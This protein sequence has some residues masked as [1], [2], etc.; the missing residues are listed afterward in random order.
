[1][2]KEFSQS[3]ALTAVIILTTFVYILTSSIAF[4]VLCKPFFYAQIDGLHLEQRSGLSR[5]QIETAYSEV[6]DYCIGARSDFAVGGLRYSESGKQHFVDCRK[7][8]IFDLALFAA[9]TALLIA[10]LLIKRKCRVECARILDRGPGF[11]GGLMALVSFAVI[12]GLGSINFDKTFVIFH[13]IFFPGKE[14]WILDYRVDEVIKIFPED[15][16]MNCAIAIVALV[17]IQSLIFILCNRRKR[18]P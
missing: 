1:M 11:W 6:V 4:P 14:N 10:W 3:K 5:E 17:I 12:G 15:F 9:S 2:R 8:F 16:F 13:S 7:L 18:V